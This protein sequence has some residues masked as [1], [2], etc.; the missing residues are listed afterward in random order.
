MMA[1][2]DIF[3]G[4]TSQLNSP[5]ADGFAITPADGTDLS[6]ACRSIYVGVA[7]DVQVTTVKG[8]TLIFKNAQAG[9]TIPV[10]CSRVWNTN[11]TATNLLGLI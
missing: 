10:R 5:A 8:T 2:L 11:T 4:W 9:S 1:V 7:G 3:S 6:F